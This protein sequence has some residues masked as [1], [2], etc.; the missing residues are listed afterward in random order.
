MVSREPILPADGRVEKKADR[1]VAVGA[2]SAPW[3]GCIVW[4][5]FKTRKP[6]KGSLLFI[7]TMSQ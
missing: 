1:H 4:R 6:N 7:I 5:G 2:P 3:K